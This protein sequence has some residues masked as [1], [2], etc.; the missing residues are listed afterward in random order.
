MDWKHA[1]ELEGKYW[2]SMAKGMANPAEVL[3][4]LAQLAYSLTPIDHGLIKSNE[5]IVEIGVGPMTIGSAVFQFPKSEIIGVDPLAPIAFTSEHPPLQEYITWLRSKVTYVQ[6]MGEKMPFEDASFD[7]VVSHNCIDHCE[8]ALDILKEGYRVLKP[9]GT[10]LL[11][12]NTFSLLGRA[13]FEFMRWLKPKQPL[14]VQHPWTFRHNQVIGHLEALG[15]K[16]VK[17]R[18]LGDDLL[19][20]YRVSFF[21]CVK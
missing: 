15:L 9:G 12:L 11:S 18:G 1:Q 7:V 13:K 19:G 16:V 2:E 6:C 5:R 17:H 14:Y 4:E 10:F 8:S 3:P 21:Q 20:K